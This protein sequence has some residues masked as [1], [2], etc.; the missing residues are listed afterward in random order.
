MMWQIRWVKVELQEFQ[1]GEIFLT[2]LWVPIFQL[3][4]LRGWR[5]PLRPP[6]EWRVWLIVGTLS[7][8]NILGQNGPANNEDG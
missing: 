7:G 5:A 8:V 3:N 6:F 2:S 1:S 4:A